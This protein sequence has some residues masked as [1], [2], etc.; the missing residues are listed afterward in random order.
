MLA[1]ENPENGAE[2]AARWPLKRFPILVDGKRTIFEASSIIE[3]LDAHY[4]GRA[5]LIPVDPDLAIDVR[6]MDR[7]RA[8]PSRWLIVRQ[9]R[10]CFMRIGY[11]RF[12]SACRT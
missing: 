3:Y 4:P 1:P 10:R 7:R 12:R 11:S 5:R 9:H 6:M 2:F 8:T